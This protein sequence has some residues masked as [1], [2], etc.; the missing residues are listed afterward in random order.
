MEVVA[1][2]PTGEEAITAFREHRPDVMTLGLRLPDMSGE[3]V[4]SRILKEYPAARIVV[5]TSSRRDAQILRVLAAG[6]RGLVLKGMSHLE[7]IATIRQVHAGKKVIPHEIASMLAEHLG[8]ETLTPR[9]IQV[10]GLVAHGN[11][12]KQVAA[13]LSIADETVRMH[14]KNILGKLGANDRTHAVTIALARGMLCL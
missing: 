4:V 8:E 7:L 9:E 12:N 14:M 3:E 13:H 5:L 2:S 6:V 10:L 11:R 1:G